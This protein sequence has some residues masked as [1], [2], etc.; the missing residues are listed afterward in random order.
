MMKRW[1]R[2]LAGTMAVA[3]LM[4]LL[5]IIPGLGTTAHA[6]ESTQD[7]YGFDL[8]VPESFDEDDGVNPY[9]SAAITGHVNF[10]PVRELGIFESAAGYQISTALNMD[11]DNGFSKVLPTD[12]DDN[13]YKNNDGLL[14]GALPG[15]TQ[16]HFQH[17]DDSYLDHVR[18]VAYDPNGTGKDDHIVYYGFGSKRYSVADGK[19]NIPGFIEFDATQGAT[20]EVHY[21]NRSEESYSWIGDRES[22]RSDG[23][24]ALVAGDFD[25][26]G[27]DTI[28]IYDP[29]KGQLSLQE[30]VE[31]DGN[32]A[33]TIDIG[34]DTTLAGYFNGIKLNEIQTGNPNSISRNT[35]IVH[36]TAGD[37]D[38]DGDEELVAT[39]SLGDL[40]AGKEGDIG[41]NSYEDNGGSTASVVA[42]YNKE[43]SSWK[44]VHSSQM[45]NVYDAE[46][47]NNKSY[48]GWFMRSA[49][50]AIGDID[51]DGSPEIVT[52]GLPA[53]DLRHN[54]DD[55]WGR[56]VMVFTVIDCG[57]GYSL[58]MVDNPTKQGSGDTSAHPDRIPEG[59]YIPNDAGGKF[60]DWAPAQSGEASNP[61]LSIGCV[62][63]EGTGTTPYV[64]ARGHIFQFTNSSGKWM[65]TAAKN[66]GDQDNH[67]NV[68]CPLQ[69]M[70]YVSQPVIANF[71]GNKEGRQ[72]IFFVVGT[73]N[74]GKLL[75]GA[76][77][78]NNWIV[79][80]T[81]DPGEGENNVMEGTGL[82]SSRW[83]TNVIDRYNDHAV[84]VVLTAPDIDTDDGLLAQYKSKQYT[85]ADPEIMAI[86]EASP[87]FEDLVDEYAETAGSTTF[88]TGTG[89]GS[90][91]SETSSTSA[92]A[93]MSFSQDFGPLGFS[94]FS[95]EMEASFESEWSSEVEMTTEYNYEMSFETGRDYNQVLLTRT[96]VIVYT[97]EVTDPSGNTS[98]MNI[99]TA[100]QPLYCMIPV[101]K[102]NEMAQSLGDTVIDSD[103]VSA[104][105]GQPDT[106]RTNTNDLVG[107]NP[108]TLGGNWID[109]GGGG[110]SVVTQSITKSNT[111][112]IT[113]SLTHSFDTKVGAG[114]L[115]LTLGVSGGASQGKAQ[116][117]TSTDSVTRA[118]TVSSVPVGYADDY[119]FQWQFMT[120]DAQIDGYTV[121]VLSYLVKNVKQ[122]PSLPQNVDAVAEADSVTLSWEAGF[123]S[124]EYYEIV[125]YLPGD[126]TYNYVGTVMGNAADENGM[127]TYEVTGLAPGKS[128]S[129]SLRAVGDGKY[130]AYTEPLTVVTAS[131]GEDLPKVLENPSDQDLRPGENAQ[132]KI[133]AVSG[134]TGN[135][136]TFQ[137]QMRKE[138]QIAWKNIQNANGNKL[139]LNNVTEDMDGNQYRCQVSQLGSADENKVF[140]YSEAATL[141]VGMGGSTTS[142]TVNQAG[143]TADYVET[144]PDEKTVTKIYAV[145]IGEE[146]H[147]YYAYQTDTDNPYYYCVDD[148]KYYRLTGLSMTGGDAQQSGV[149]A[150]TAASRTELVNLS[151]ALVKTEGDTATRITSL[152]DLHS[153]VQAT[154]TI[155]ETNYNVFTAQGVAVDIKDNQPA[156]TL[157]E[158]TLTLYQKAMDSEEKDDEFY[159]EVRVYDTESDSMVMKLEK[160]TQ[161]TGEELQNLTYFGTPEKVWSDTEYETDDGYTVLT[162]GD[163]ETKIYQKDS[164]YYTRTEDGG[165]DGESTSYKYAKLTLL[166]TTKEGSGDSLVTTTPLGVVTEGV[167]SDRIDHKSNTP[168][169]VM[170]ITTTTQASKQGAPVT[171]AAEVTGNGTGKV[172]FQIVNTTTGS[173][174]QVEATLGD[175]TA[176]ATWRPTVAGVYQI[177]AIYQ[178]DSVTKPSTS[179]PV[180]YYAYENPEAT[181]G[182]R[183]TLEESLS[184]GDRINPEL[185]RW[186][187]QDDGSIQETSE[188]IGGVKY[189]AYAYLGDGEEDTDDNGYAT[190]PVTDWTQG[191]ILPPGNYLIRATWGEE[192]TMT[193][194]AQLAVTKR[195][196]TVTAP[197][198]E[199]L[200]A[201]TVSG[202]DLADHLKDI[203]V[204]EEN[205]LEADE[206]IYGAAKAGY[207][208]LFCLTGGLQ[209]SAG[210]YDI[211][212]DYTANGSSP[213]EDHS[214]AYSDFT[215]KYLPTLQKSVVYVK[216][217]VVNVTYAAGTNGRLSAQ[218]DGRTVQSGDAVPIGEE[219]VFIA[220]PEKDFQVSRWLIDG[221][222]VDTNTSGVKLLP[223]QNAM[224]VKSV[225]AQM[226]V[227]V[228]FSNESY[229]VNF[230]ADEN[231]TVTAAAADGTEI[232]NGTTVVGGSTVTFTAQPEEGYVVKNWTVGGTEQKNEDGSAYSGSTLTLEN[233][234]EDTNV[235][236]TFEK[237]EEY[238]VT[239]TAVDN[240]EKHEILETGVTLT[241][242][243]LDAKGKA[244][245]GSTV[246]LMATPVPGNA[247]LEWQ[248]QRGDEWEFLAEAQESYTIQ[249]LQSDMNIRVVVNT[250]ATTYSVTFGIYAEGDLT[251]PIKEAGTL[252]AT[253]NSTPIESGN[254]H[255][256]GSTVAF[257]YKEPEGYEFVRWIVNDEEAGNEP[258]YTEKNL[259]ENLT[260][261]AVVK[262]KPQV[263]IKQAEHGTVTVM[264]GDE[265]VNSGDYIYNGTNLNVTLKPDKGYEVDDSINA[266]Y[267]DGSGKTTD[268]K[269]YTL[270]DVQKDQTI[271]PAWSELPT[272]K[273]AFS[274]VNTETGGGG[275]HG[276]LTA[277]VERKDMEAYAVSNFTSGGDVY[278]DSTVTFTAVADTGYRV[279]EWKIGGEVYRTEDDPF[280][281][282]VL[283]LP[284]DQ[285]TGEV[286]VQFELGAALI[287]FATPAHGTLTAVSAGTDFTS[288]GSS[289]ADVV[290]T[291]APEENYEVKAWTVNGTIV[292]GETGTQF[293]YRP[294]GANAVVAVELQ[295]VVLK[296]DA[297]AGA[298]GTVSGL[299]DEVRYD[300]QVTLKATPNAGYAFEG[301]YRDGKRI[302]DADAAYTFTATEAASYEARFTPTAD[303]SVTFS[304][305]DEKMGSITATANGTSIDS[306]D[307]LTGGQTIVFTVAPEAGYRVKEWSGLPK[308]A[309][310]SEDKTT[311]TVSALSSA[312]TVQAEL[313]AIPQRTVTLET[314]EGQGTIT[315]QVDGKTVT[316]VPDGTEVTFTASP[317][318]GWM[319]DQWTGDA[320]G[321]K[322][323]SFTMAVT[324]DVTISAKF[325]GAVHYKVKY[326]VEGEGGDVS[327]EANGSTNVP[328]DTAVQ[329][330]ANSSVVFTAVPATGETKYMV[331]KWSVNEVEQDTLSNT[332]TI[333]KLSKNT[334]VTVEFE[335][336][337]GFDIPTGGTGY[338]ISDVVR[339]PADTYKDAPK[340][341]IRKGGDL[342]FTVKPTGG[343]TTISKLVINGY[344]CIAK[345][346]EV[347]NCD[348]V[349]AVKKSNGSYTVTI[350]GVRSAITTD[351]VAHQVVVG[352][353]TVPGAFKDNPDLDTVDKIQS[354]LTAAVTGS[355]DGIVYYD[356]AL[357][358]FDGGKWVEVTKENFPKNGVDVVLSYP[359]GTDS[360]DTFTIVHML[361]TGE[362]AGKT[363]IVK[364]QKED[365]GLHFHVNSLS[366]FAIS[367]EKYEAP[368]TPP[369]GGGGG[370]GGGAVSTDYAVTVET[371]PHGTVTADRETAK[372]GDTVRLIVQAESGY[373]LDTI[374][375]TGKSGKDVA[376]TGEAG[377]YTFQMPAEGVTVQA[378]FRP[379][380]NPFTD[381]SADAWYYDAVMYVYT[382]GLMTGTS[383][384]TFAPDLTTT[385]GMVVTI[386]YRL[387]GS[388]ELE[389]GAMEQPFEDVASGAYYE[390]AVY[391]ARM[392]GIVDGY[393]SESFG[394]DNTITREQ[395]ATILYRY[396]QH[397]GYDTTAR[398][399]LSNYTDAEQVG[400]WALDAI[401]W[402]NAEGLVSGTSST[403][404]SPKGSATRAQVAMILTRFCQNIAD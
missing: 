85:W 380:V 77:K 341:E 275:T 21:L 316:S 360:K 193:A 354:K 268:D 365:S 190:K 232:S 379:W 63:L 392:N 11:R 266:A 128:Y 189:T 20:N 370:G 381:V 382:H 237:S 241:S 368:V 66:L 355:R 25:G 56:D 263:T 331:A 37:L 28:M 260:V 133:T 48:K 146:P 307:Q 82:Y 121:P 398:A 271:T 319:L 89:S 343:Y 300:E 23:Y 154:E 79:G 30:Y 78:D 124:A 394:P 181:T 333:D 58:R 138:G 270:S 234:S 369:E 76:R 123:N 127:Y 40:D 41:G 148:G 297:Q 302:G 74:T 166:N 231:G 119:G 107:K 309:E 136:I 238:T 106:Y 276:K 261:K 224:I 396:A 212:V 210:S 129:Y 179:A 306:G 294:N 97:Y 373:A 290:F 111:Q 292:E 367:W 267:T 75:N 295:G 304:V 198:I 342:T 262:K 390:A 144:T 348:S 87:Y 286:T 375:V 164:T 332:L 110:N 84:S 272:K 207:P 112:G 372:E 83:N 347:T 288:G 55:L 157:E 314:P 357:K 162:F 199:T 252:S 184:Y 401:R 52:V 49:A 240:S 126:G 258:S 105:P 239:F 173:E 371:A 182:Y 387:A 296:I 194:S 118:G 68:D 147:N 125:R 345:S 280:R 283:T 46:H 93:Y 54:D 287:T 99:T 19:K 206:T 150:G 225:S 69:D 175:G 94:I 257:A 50:S 151:G 364:Y 200:S 139:N 152:D 281:G 91:T 180:T 386:L 67:K 256:N 92:G 291:V 131:Q 246:T 277:A 149:F 38:G 318:S 313:E 216:A 160:V 168:A 358:Y 44:L 383:A 220:T 45:A 395:L 359:D 7:A 227:R 284:Y 351:I 8:N 117:T 393:S 177:T 191:G 192:G 301:W 226:D 339:D 236:V 62:Q 344:D 273:V 391:W 335:E 312:L 264:A 378:A 326:Q 362:D 219:L 361:T 165:G 230:S 265:T 43:G 279:M 72:Q 13:R 174:Q 15:N 233:I 114:V 217:D 172:V 221:K 64:F 399:D 18:G 26:D 218:V 73:R 27:Q 353:L 86:L 155:G 35:A 374:T 209:A 384:D 274:V 153:T 211:N 115:G 70:T 289:S 242:E 285:L 183:L 96:P 22:W 244:I 65:F 140:V 385:R 3:M 42:V 100:E 104:V 278:R 397:M 340:D 170:E 366:P 135:S 350:S 24:N 6:A 103:I 36:L 315:A 53:D 171:L 329:L 39:I 322:G 282:S 132:F 250:E 98:E 235:A 47:Q 108:Q 228:E 17:N 134:G 229:T 59:W 255:P 208:N 163:D 321:Q 176:T 116:S 223:E 145:T 251:N 248:V 156:Y 215:S 323:D 142:V 71:D 203:S 159:V 113:T 305:N 363:E 202:F 137:W 9:G 269:T 330:V 243:G 328:I 14:T 51:G 109:A 334:V 201:E 122:P 376:V 33:G 245:K 185:V 388:P 402:A 303:N 389:E 169:E 327:A 60:G 158:S 377:S 338:T 186:E 320:A 356:I 311:A 12:R 336:Y 253:I 141:S 349:A 324:E 213:T 57:S 249:N 101:E 90:G 5:P 325:T 205:I 298:G 247:I 188:T 32:P 400:A 167:I 195:A 254:Q 34:N 143:G 299:P 259:M 29:Q 16:N 80:L 61:P 293:T 88:G 308:D 197:K 346:G 222:E 403:T 204:T 10:N 95:A 178:G 120:W 161:A 102:Y 352:G 187:G 196:V 317:A 81:Y 2:W 337:Q 404:L 1:K 310:L 4:G 130:S 214:K 31:V